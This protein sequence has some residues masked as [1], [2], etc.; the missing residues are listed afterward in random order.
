MKVLIIEDETLLAKELQRT[1]SE[2][3]SDIE[4]VEVIKSISQGTEWF[5]KGEAID[6]IISDIQL[7]DGTSFELLRQVEVSTPIIFTTAYDEFAINAFK[8]NSIDYLLK[9][10]NENDLEAA[11]EKFEELWGKKKVLAL[12]G[13]YGVMTLKMKKQDVYPETLEAVKTFTEFLTY[14]GKVYHLAKKGEFRLN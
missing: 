8:L 6:L 7:T 14:L 1:L 9:P 11:L 13:V 10:I 3:R 5:Q 12:N 4:I 2:I